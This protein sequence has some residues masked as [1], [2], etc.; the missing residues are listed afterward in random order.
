MEMAVDGNNNI[1]VVE[2]LNNKVCVYNS[3]GV[4]IR[5]I[6]GDFNFPIGVAVDSNNNIYVTDRRNNVIKKFNSSGS[7]IETWTGFNLPWGITFYNGYIYV[8]EFYK[9]KKLRPDGV[10]VKEWGSSGIGNGQF[11]LAA[12][13][14]G[15]NNLLYVADIEHHRI[16]VFDLDGNFIKIIGERGTGNGQFQFPT[17]IAI[18]RNNNWLYV[19]DDDNN[20]I[21]KFDISTANHGKY[22]TQWGC[23]SSGTTE[24]R[25][26]TKIAVDNIN[27]FLYIVDSGK[28]RIRKLTLNMQEIFS[29]GSYGDGNGQFRYPID[30]AVDNSGNVYVV[31][32]VNR[33]VQKFDLDGIFKDKWNINFD[34]QIYLYGL[35]GITVDKDGYIYVVD[36]DTKKLYKL[37][38]NGLKVAGWDI[39][40]Y[41]TGIDIDEDNGFIYIP[42]F[43]VGS[44]EADTVKQYD[45]NGIPTGVIIGK[46]F[47]FHPWDVTVV[48]NGN[49][50]V[51]DT[52][53]HRVV[54]F[55]SSGNYITEWGSTGGIMDDSIEP[56]KFAYPYGVAVDKNGYAYVADTNNHRIQKFARVIFDDVPATYW[57]LPFINKIYDTGITSGCSATP[58]LYCPENQVTRAE[59]AVFMTKALGEAPAASCTGAVFSDVNV[60]TVG[61]GFCKYIEKFS[62]LGI[63]VGCQVD[64]AATPQNEAMYCPSNNVTRAEMAVFMTKAL[65]QPPAATCTGTIFNDVNNAVM[66]DGFCRYIEKFSTLGITSGCQ[67]DNPATPGNEARYC[68]ESDVTRAQMA[69]FLTKGFLQ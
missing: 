66:A 32:N 30:V 51:T 57:A 53:N 40:Y 54:K 38:S 19:T 26:P 37:D 48:E 64:N 61:E 47:L 16:Q 44:P 22:L 49:L 60:S 52:T 34:P 9:V 20:R 28:H 65:N 69:V 41:S 12:G 13:I 56:G 31:D 11:L 55:D 45:M 21:V 42:K 36:A 63:T 6:T 7:L 29:W 33:N 35:H 14:A 5:T 8:A 15:Q 1:Y 24:L 62:S 50:L 67:A 10:L 58:L 25:Y 18:D 27:G 39:D 46:G 4:Y 23:D 3:S 43:D 17:A 2:M 68:P 59:M